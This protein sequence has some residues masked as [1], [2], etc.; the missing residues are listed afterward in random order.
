[1]SYIGDFAE[2]YA[3]LNTKFTTVKST[4]E[5]TVLSN[6]PV[7]S[8]YKADG[9]SPS[10]AGVTLTVS[11]NSTVGQNNVLMH[12]SADAFYAVGNDY[13]VVITTGTVDS[14]SVVGYVV[15]EF[16]IENRFMRGTDSVVLAGPTKTEMDTA[17]GLLATP[18]QVNAQ[19]LDVMV[20]DTFGEPAQGAP[21]NTI[22]MEEKISFLYAA[23]INKVD[24]DATLKEF[25]NAANAVIWKKTLADG[26]TNYNEAKGA[27]GP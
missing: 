24:V 8:V 20:T 17:H 13:Q 18:A 4:G 15:A 2:D 21:G 14:V 3:T 10:T 25:Y 27:T 19:V 5:P 16:S 11:H 9:V 7:I 1:M 22:S 23:L 6:S 12:L 26:G